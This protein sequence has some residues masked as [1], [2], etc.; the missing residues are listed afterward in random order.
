MRRKKRSFLLEINLIS[1]NLTVGDIQSSR[2]KWFVVLGNRR[3]HMC[4]RG[5]FCVNHNLACSML[6]RSETESQWKLLISQ[7]TMLSI[8]ELCNQLCLAL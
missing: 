5:Q 8:L 2:R 3:R 1:P 7:D 4:D 6:S